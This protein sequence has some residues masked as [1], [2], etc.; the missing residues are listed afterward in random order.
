MQSNG[1]ICPD[2]AITRFWRHHV[3]RSAAQAE[4][5]GF[6]NLSIESNNGCM[7]LRRWLSGEFRLRAVVA[8]IPVAAKYRTAVTHVYRSPPFIGN[9]V[10]HL[11][12][13]SIGQDG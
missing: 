11:G 2:V 6:R 5:H 13:I 8:E 9:A 7:S 3:C 10:C 4:R 1:R 12:P